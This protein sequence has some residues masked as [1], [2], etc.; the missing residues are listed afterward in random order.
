MP[1]I[2]MT[3]PGAAKP[4]GSKNGY[5]R[6]GGVVLVESVKGLKESRLAASA[7]IHASAYEDKWVMPNAAA[8]VSVQM[9]FI[10]T[11]PKSAL[12]RIFHTVKPDLD[13]LTR[14]MLDALTQAGNVIHD[15]NQVTEIQCTKIYGRMNATSIRVSYVD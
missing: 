2:E 8:P 5:I 11:R 15:D 14:Y 7:Q 12:T 6:G 10:F 9:V 13:K 4:Q 3:I 1:E